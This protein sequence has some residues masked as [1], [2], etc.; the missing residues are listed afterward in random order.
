M[1]AAK[2]KRGPAAKDAEKEEKRRREHT[3]KELDEA[4][5]DTFPASDPVALTESSIPRR[6]VHER[7]KKKKEDKD[8]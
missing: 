1:P 7:K 4:L 2:Q 5:E 3:E 6:P 8:C